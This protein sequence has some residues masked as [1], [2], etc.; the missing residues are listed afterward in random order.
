MVIYIHIFN[1]C[2]R[3]NELLGGKNAGRLRSARLIIEKV[4][5]VCVK[6]SSGV[7]QIR[8]L[9]RAKLINQNCNTSSEHFFCV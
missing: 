8:H 4:L 5:P 9:K 1:E 2:V 6:C 3:G 7:E